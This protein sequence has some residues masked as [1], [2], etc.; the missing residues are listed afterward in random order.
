MKEKEFMEYST[1]EIFGQL[2]PHG[3]VFFDEE[4]GAAFFNWTCSG[5]SLRFTGSALKVKILAIEDRLTFPGD[6]P[7]DLPCIGLV[8]DDGETI[9]WRT[10]C[11]KGEA[12]YNVIHADTSGTHTVRIVKLSENARGKTGLLAVAT[13][14]EILKWGEEKKPLSIEFIGDSITCGY[15]NEA[16]DRDDHFDTAEENGWVTY[17]AV[18]ARELGAEFNMISVSGISVSSPEHLLF[19][20]EPMDQIYEYRAA[21]FDE[22]RRRRPISWNFSENKKN[23]V[24]MNIG[25]NDV[26]PIRFNDNLA[27]ADREEVHFRKSY[28]AFLEKLRKLNGKDTYIC[29]TLGPLDYYL[30]DVISETVTNYV[31]ETGDDRVGCLKM[32]GVNLLTEGFGADGHPSAATH[33]RMGKELAARLRGL[34]GVL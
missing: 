6:A 11:V 5:F 26:N 29:C 2:E 4:T 13:D 28:R 22:S 3:R 7:E 19:P 32:R 9:L 15:G 10:K 34:E 31:E 12:W 30:Y 20:S 8:G 24:V 17:G 33:L 16:S 21:L 18:A 14:G 25:T 27:D 1:R 23:I